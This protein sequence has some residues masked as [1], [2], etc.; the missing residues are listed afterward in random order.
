VGCNVAEK[1]YTCAEDGKSYRV[2]F[3]YV[4]AKYRKLDVQ[5]ACLLYGWDKKLKRYTDKHRFWRIAGINA[6]LATRSIS[7]SHI[8]LRPKWFG[9]TVFVDRDA[10]HELYTERI[11]SWVTHR[12]KLRKEPGVHD[13]PPNAPP[14]WFP[15]NVGADEE[16]VKELCSE[17]LI[18]KTL[19]Q[20]TASEFLPSA[21]KEFEWKRKGPNHWGDAV[22]VAIVGYRWIT[23]DDAEPPKPEPSED[24]AQKQS[25]MLAAVLAESSPE[26]ISPN[27]GML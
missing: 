20:A 5:R 9:V 25:A 23:R 24:T 13:D 10:K 12:E 6:D 21:A 2:T 27:C 16:F 4:D 11:N 8:P 1:R 26:K 22:K 17:H 14:L 7:F 19:D 3:G 18:Q 15:E